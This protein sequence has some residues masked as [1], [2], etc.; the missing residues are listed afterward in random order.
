MD[1]AKK[2]AD[3]LEANKP[4]E[5]LVEYTR[6]LIEHPSS[7]DYHI[8]RS[9]AFTRAGKHELALQ[10]SDSALHF[11]HQRSKRESIQAAQH[12][13]VVALYNLGRYGDAKHLL[14]SM[15]KWVNPTGQ[16]KET[17]Q[18]NMWQT[19]VT[20][21]LKTATDQQKTVTV[22]ETPKLHLPTE[23]VR[24]NNFKRQIKSDGTYNFDWENEPETVPSLAA[25][26]TTSK[27]PEPTP[28]ISP[29]PGG[30]IRHEWYQ[31]NQSVIVTIYAKGVSKEKAEIDIQDDSV[32]SPNLSR[33]PAL[34]N[35]DHSLLPRPHK[36]NH[37]IFNH[38]RPS[39]RPHQCLK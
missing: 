30:K 16:N 13:R 9:I 6:A 10:D 20:N 18:F 39:F 27:Q 28:T 4:L 31:N 36:P 5:A 24:V 25:T 19:K 26:N 37:H 38:L 11:G 1:A 14:D 12:R 8:Q 35:S 15:Q 23:K 34:T 2:G 3:A 22:E 32:G 17:M 21:K 29:T 7:P 33:S